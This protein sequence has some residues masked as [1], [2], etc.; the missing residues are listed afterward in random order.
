MSNTEDMLELKTQIVDDLS[1]I[2]E[3]IEDGMTLA[4]YEMLLNLYC[5]DPFNQEV[6]MEVLN[7][8]VILEQGF[9]FLK[10]MDESF[11]ELPFNVKDEVASTLR[12][13]LDIEEIDTT[14]IPEQI[15]E[16]MSAPRYA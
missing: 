5:R 8:S 3:D 11:E 4:S 14:I 13:L 12:V 6:V 15:L 2:R 9:S 7:L 10:L 1:R 16:Y